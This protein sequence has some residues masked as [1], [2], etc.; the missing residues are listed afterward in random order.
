MAAFAMPR[1]R[2]AWPLWL[3][4]VSL[5]V[6]LLALFII[7]LRRTGGTCSYA[8]DDAYIH[9]AM[10][11][12]FAE[13]GVWGVAPD[14]FSSSSSSPLWTLILALLYRVARPLDS[15]PLVLAALFAILVLV[16][17]YAFLEARGVPP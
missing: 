5:G 14:E 7:V 10:A 16:A 12:H 3:A 17:A 15:A 9:M 13:H 1:L 6:T 2:H 4:V 8:L 11:R